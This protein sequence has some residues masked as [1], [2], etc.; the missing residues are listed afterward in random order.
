MEKVNH[1]VTS[2]QQQDH[3]GANATY[4]Q[5]RKRGLSKEPA[6]ES[7]KLE[8]SEGFVSVKD[9]KKEDQSPAKEESKTI[10]EESKRVF[11]E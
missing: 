1:R 8:I 6:N 5:S 9:A 2:D 3:S 10:D 4:L 11:E 7:I